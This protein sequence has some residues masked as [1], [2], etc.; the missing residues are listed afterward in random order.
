M[1]PVLAAPAAAPLVGLLQAACANA[2]R[3]FADDRGFFHALAEVEAERIDA[4]WASLDGRG[5]AINDDVVAHLACRY[6]DLLRRLGNAGQQNSATNQLSFL[7]SMLPSGQE[8]NGL[9]GTLK[10]LADGVAKE[11]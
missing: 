1:P 6:R 8:S 11:V 4:L 9:K 3:R 10:Q 2:R 7:I 5:I